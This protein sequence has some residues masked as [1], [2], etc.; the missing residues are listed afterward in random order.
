VREAFRVAD[1]LIP[2]VRGTVP[3]AE[4]AILANERDQ[5]LTDDGTYPDF[6]GANK[7]LMDL[8]WPFDVVTTEHL[9]STDL[10]SFKLLL[11][12]NVLHLSA[13]HRQVVLEYLR[14]GGHLFFCGR[15]AVLDEN[16]KPHHSPNFGLAKIQQETHA[17]RGYVKTSFPIDDERL[18][19]AEIMI[20]EA[21]ARQKVWAR[22]IQTSVTRRAGSP[23]EDVAYPMRLTDLPVIVSGEEGQGQFTYV[24]Y[25]F[26]QEYISQGLPVIKQAFTHL[27]APYYQPAVW[28]EAPSFVEAIY[29]Q[30][31]TEL[32]V[33]LVNGITGR[34][35][36]DGRGVGSGNHGFLNIVEVVPVV[37]TKILL[38]GKRV[39]KATNLNGE[40]L[41]VT[42]GEGSTVIRV[43]RL[44][45]YDLISLD[46]G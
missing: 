20:V 28:V 40:Q 5:I 11:V 17:P 38:R 27:V 3:Y 39:R 41:R 37:D 9:S 35:A 22:L 4:I 7:L 23:L 29:N 1:R 34:P 13:Q 8:H 25:R 12:P 36:G 19:A 14:K 18:K 43:P 32:R 45:Q 30:T 46:L 15:C 10:A 42:S 24:G 31:G 16:G 2:K 33:S 26:F 21:D 44:E 6:Y